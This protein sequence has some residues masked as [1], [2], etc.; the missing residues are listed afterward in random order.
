M[1]DE[2]YPAES[3]A[4]SK[5]LYQEL[6]DQADELGKV[7]ILGGWA[8]YEHVD[9]VR[10]QESQ[11]L[12]LL[13]HDQATWD[14]VIPRL[15]RQGFRWRQLGRRVRDQRLE[16]RD[17]DHVAVDIFYGTDVDNDLLRRHFGTRWTANR[18]DQPFEGF[19]PPL[20]RVLQDKID[21][22][23]KRS[24]QDKELKQLKDVIDIHSLLSHNREERD[25]EELV[26]GLEPVSIQKAL[27]VVEEIAERRVDYRGEI[28]GVLEVLG[29]GG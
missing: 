24:G 2:F 16:H 7:T 19:V 27:E 3:T 9:P 21:T 20:P 10:A 14:E 1:A 17:H 22:L 5:R 12:D 23:P 29:G 13:I 11:D 8:V 15:V 26:A 28:E 6:K 18:K 4:F 25:A